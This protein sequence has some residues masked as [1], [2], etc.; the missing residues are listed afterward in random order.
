ME[1]KKKKL[2]NGMTI[3]F[4]KR[5]LPLVSVSIANRFGGA[6]EESKEKGVA[7]FIEHM[8][9]TGTETRTHEDISREIE[10]KGGILNAFTD[11]E[12]TCFWFKIPSEHMFAGLDILT[13]I[14]NNPTF[15][16]DKFEKEK[17]VILEEIK[18]YHDSPQKFVFDEIE[19]NMYEKPFGELIIGNKE[20]V[21]GLSRD[22]VKAWFEKA[23]SPENYIVSVVGDADFDELCEYF[24]KNFKRK[25]GNVEAKKIIKKLGNSIEE[26]ESIDQAHIIIGMHAPLPSDE[27]KTAAL[28]VL[29]AYMGS[30]MSSRLF[31]E[32]RENRGLAYTVRGIVNAGINHSDYLIYAGTTKEAVEEVKKIIF[33]EFGKIDEMGEKDLEEA[34]ERILG[35]RHI[36][37]ED[38]DGVMNELL[39]E[40]LRGDAEKYYK[41]EEGI[42]R[43]RL[44]EVKELAGELIKEHSTAV[45]VPK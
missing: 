35:L 32:I 8:L 5:E 19:R 43:V 24:E 41:L 25:G 7:H 26:R 38:S 6:Y 17:K 37:R 30:G 40:E 13:D 45:V 12:V 34:K 23:Y 39:Y 44:D 10:K 9:F 36:S 11:H 16:E 1:F 20:T 3:L 22:D 29:N 31:L 27:K 4:E 14:L 33:E 18:M 2:A 21:S 28:E 42:Q 15:K